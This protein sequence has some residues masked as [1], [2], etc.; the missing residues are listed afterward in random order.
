MQNVEIV[1]AILAAAQ[2]TK[3][4]LVGPGEL[5]AEYRRF[6]D[7]LNSEKPAARKSA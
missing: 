4:E 2:Y 1:A 3:L 7:L 6:V 5:V